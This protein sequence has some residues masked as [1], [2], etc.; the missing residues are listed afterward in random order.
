MEDLRPGVYGCYRKSSSIGREKWVIDISCLSRYHEFPAHLPL[1]IRDTDCYALVYSTTSREGFD[2]MRVWHEDIHAA[3]NNWIS[4]PPPSL[5]L[6]PP[7]LLALIATQCDVPEPQRQVTA[8][9]GVEL[10]RELGCLFY[11]TSA[12]TAH[13]VDLVFETMGRLCRDAI[14]LHS[15]SKTPDLDELRKLMKGRFRY[16][17]DQRYA[18]LRGKLVRSRNEQQ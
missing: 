16:N 12:K 15:I 3:R 13:N 17:I 8:D 7:V 4:T 10:A 2:S 14:R 5:R 9:E 6:Q 18:S 11:E 1:H